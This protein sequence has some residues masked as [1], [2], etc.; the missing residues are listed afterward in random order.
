MV[1]PANGKSV[2]PDGVVMANGEA[3]EVAGVHVE[4]VAAYDVTPGESFHPKGEANG[5]ILT[6]GGTRI[7]VAGVTECVPEVRGVRDVD[8]STAAVKRT[9]W[10]KATRARGGC[11]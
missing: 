5:Y 1:I 2:V 6:V 4:A 3:R 8:T 7:Y 9:R 11:G 10:G